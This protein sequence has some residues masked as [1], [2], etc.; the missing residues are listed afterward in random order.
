MEQKKWDIKPW[1]GKIC[2]TT[3]LK[4]VDALYIILIRDG[5]RSAREWENLN[6]KAGHWSRFIPEWEGEVSRFRKKKL[7]LFKN[8][9][10]SR[11]PQKHFLPLQRLNVDWQWLLRSCIETTAFRI[12]HTCRKLKAFLSRHLESSCMCTN[13]LQVGNCASTKTQKKKLPTFFL[14]FFGTSF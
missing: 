14:P 5:G 2:T 9:G 8:L 7:I 11:T 4:W 12:L 1:L 3:W 6:T 13:I 10:R